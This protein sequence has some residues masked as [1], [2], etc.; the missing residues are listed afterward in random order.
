MAMRL[1]DMSVHSEQRLRASSDGVTRPEQHPCPADQ[2]HGTAALIHRG[3]ILRYFGRR[4]A[5]H[6][7]PTMAVVARDTIG[8][9][10]IRTEGSRCHAA[11]FARSERRCVCLL[12]PE[13]QRTRWPR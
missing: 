7:M 12:L 3:F 2:Q 5:A 1:C 4:A 11:Y 9:A 6:D 13:W 8:D 10:V